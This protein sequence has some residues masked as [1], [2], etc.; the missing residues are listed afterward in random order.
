MVLPTVG[1]RN[2]ASHT[3]LDWSYIKLVNMNTPPPELCA[4]QS[5]LGNFS[6]E[7]L[8]V[9]ISRLCQVDGQS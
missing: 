9:D 3:G 5:D 1:V 4:G 6:N 8:S 2:G 7:I